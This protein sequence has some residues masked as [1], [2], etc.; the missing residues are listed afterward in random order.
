MIKL[1]L[2]D[3]DG[4]LTI[5]RGTYEIDLDAIRALRELEKYGIKVGLV[6]GNSYPVLRSLYTYFNFHGGLVAENGCVVYYNKMIKVCEDINKSLIKEFETKFNVKGSWQNEFKC[7]DLSFTPPILTQ[8]M[9]EWAKSKGL[10]IKTSGYAIHIS[11][12]ISGKGIGVRKLIE[13]HNLSKEEVLGIGDSST[14]K[15]FLEEVGIKVVVGN[16]DDEVKK[17]ANYITANKSGKG[18]VEVVEKI[19]KGEINGRRN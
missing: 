5:E 2:T 11:K 8:E 3:V 13:L 10:Y 1:V 9:I 6:S 17:I 14:D 16:A 4:T 7:C 12:S 19:L 18:V 15:E